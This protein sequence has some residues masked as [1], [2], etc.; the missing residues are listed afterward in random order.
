[1]SDLTQ[2]M[3]KEPSSIHAEASVQDAAKQIRD[4]RIGSLLVER[5]NQLVGILTE[6]DIVKGV[7]ADGFDL[8]QIL[9][10]QIMSSP[11]LTLESDR[12]VID[13]YDMMADNGVRHLAVTEGGRIVG[14]VSVRD[15]LAY[16]K[17]WSEPKIGID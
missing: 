11:I 13:A 2:L 10:H 15:I 17:T 14:V 7:A 3:T 4:S 5:A 1:M 12:S 9:V 8:G 16:F 6:T